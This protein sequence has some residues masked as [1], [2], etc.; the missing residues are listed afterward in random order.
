MKLY[1]LRVEFHGVLLL[2][3][4]NFSFC[5]SLISFCIYLKQQQ[6]MENTKNS[7]FNEQL[8]LITDSALLNWQLSLYI[9]KKQ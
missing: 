4:I 1:E 8:K 9:D 3:F 6:R 5:I 7:K 2:Q